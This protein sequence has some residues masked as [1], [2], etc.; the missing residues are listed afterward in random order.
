MYNYFTRIFSRYYLLVPIQIIFLGKKLQEKITLN[1]SIL[2]MILLNVSPMYML[3]K[4][5]GL[6]CFILCQSAHKFIQLKYELHQKFFSQ[7]KI[8]QITFI[9]VKNWILYTIWALTIWFVHVLLCFCLDNF[10]CLL[11]CKVYFQ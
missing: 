6:L 2:F 1:H 5:I 9:E 7:S 10:Q 11:A 8:F 4:I 3:E